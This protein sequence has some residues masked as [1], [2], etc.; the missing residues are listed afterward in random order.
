[1]VNKNRKRI[2]I[3]LSVLFL[4]LILTWVFI[5]M[6]T[7]VT[8]LYPKKSAKPLVN[9]M[10]G[11][12]PRSD[13]YMLANSDMLNNTLVYVDITW[14]ELEPR[15]GKFDF[16]LIEKENN[17]NEWR[18]MG[19]RV[20]FRFV[21]DI[22]GKVTHMDIPDWLYEETGKDGDWYDTEY[23]KGYSPNYNNEIFISTHKQAVE[24]LGARYGKDDFFL[25][26]EL[27]SLGHWGEWHT[28]TEDGIGRLPLEDIR[29]QYIQPYVDSFPNAMLLMRRPFKA[30][31]EHNM[32][33]Y[34]DMTGK[35]EDTEI[36]LDWINNG[37]EYDATGEQNA[38]VAMP[39]AWQTAPI[40]GEFTGAISMKQLLVDDIQMTKN[41]IERSH[42]SFIGPKCPKGEELQYT[43]GIEEVKSLL[44]YRLRVEKAILTKLPFCNNLNVSLCW[45]NEGIAPFYKNWEVYLYLFDSGGNEVF[46]TPIDIALNT[47]L[48]KH[49]A[50]VSETVIPISTLEEGIYNIGIAII[51]PLTN[52]PGVSLA[53]ENA[54]NDRIFLLGQ[55]ENK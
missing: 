23:G 10:I 54:R 21:C 20:V 6:N 45:I 15:K 35:V 12:A 1:M 38:L 17:L 27:G 43:H 52:E 19:K 29:N 3:I 32:G 16:D 44:G 36:W 51:D 33:I 13:Y 40:G 26:I 5:N 42:V 24:A 30:A 49:V 37:G 53:M 22:P 41:L 11:F 39:D 34:N 14:R 9:P 8:V 2:I 48:D 46:K 7:Q 18:A 4:V 50:V 25:Y 47:I 31:K 55:W 28:K